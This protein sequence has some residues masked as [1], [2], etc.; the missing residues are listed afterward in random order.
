M[1]QIST[2]SKHVLT[3]RDLGIV[4]PSSEDWIE[5]DEQPRFGRILKA[6][7]GTDFTT[8]TVDDLIKG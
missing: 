7:D 1:L 6:D 4:A 5:I 3:P 8:A 2:N